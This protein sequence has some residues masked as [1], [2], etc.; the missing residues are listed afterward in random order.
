MTL[1]NR[2]ARYM[3]YFEQIGT[4]QQGLNGNASDASSSGGGG[5]DHPPI[6]YAAKQHELQQIIE[7][8]TAEL[9][10]WQRRVSDLSGKISEL[11]ETM[12]K[13]SKDFG[14]AQEHCV[15]LTRDLRENVAQKEDQEERIATLEKRYLHA[16]RESTSLH[17]LNEKLEQELRHKEAQLKVGFYAD[18]SSICS[19]IHSTISHPR[20]GSSKTRKSLPSR[21]SWNCPTRSSPNARSCPKSR[22]S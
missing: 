9:S 13:N 2:T 16:Q 19:L 11:E 14:K 15:K 5:G 17:D 6:D 20:C 10:Q 7:K 22:S 4:V 1:V 8:Q 18:C 21:R 12:S 3:F